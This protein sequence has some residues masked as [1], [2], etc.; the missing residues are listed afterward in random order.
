MECTACLRSLD[1][2]V[3]AQEAREQLDL[4]PACEERVAAL[5]RAAVTPLVVATFAEFLHDRNDLATTT[6]RCDE[7]A[8]RF[9]AMLASFGDATDT[10]EVEAALEELVRCAPT[11][12]HQMTD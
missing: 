9:W 4:C 11:R 10:V 8:H 12:L 7:A 2:G 5:E 1:H 3:L 6:R